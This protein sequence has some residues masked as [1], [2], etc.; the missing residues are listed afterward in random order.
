[1]PGGGND[2]NTL[3]LLHCDGTNNSTTFIDSSSQAR[4]M[5][6]NG[7]A[8]LVTAQQK[9][10]T[11]SYLVDGVN[12]T[13]VTAPHISADDFGAGS[14][15]IDMWVR[16]NTISQ[17]YIINRN[18]SVVNNCDLLMNSSSNV[19]FFIMGSTVI[20]ATWSPSTA[21]WYHIAFVRNGSACDFYVNGTSVGSGSNSSSVTDTNG[22]AIGGARNGVLCFD[23]WLDEIRISNVAR[24]TTAFTPETTPYGQ[25]SAGLNQA[26]FL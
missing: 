14:F 9:F 8:K 17:K 13:F 22:W 20:N 3:L 26:I 15:T 11:A 16:F 25:A 12:G 6:A 5:T 4:T 7:G 24:W 19:Q 10:G 1:M 23:G 18:A 21:I 2:A